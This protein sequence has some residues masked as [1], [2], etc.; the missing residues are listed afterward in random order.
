MD[1]DIGRPQCGDGIQGISKSVEIIRGQ[2]GNQVHVDGLESGVF[3]PCIGTQN[4]VGGVGPFAGV[5]HAVHHGLGVDAHAIRPMLTDGQ[6]FFCVQRVRSTALYGKFDAPG[7]VERIP[8]GIQKANHLG[9]GQCGGC[10]ASYV[11]GTH[12]TSGVFQQFAGDGNFLQKCFQ[13]GFHQIC[14]RTDGAADKTAIA[15]PGGAKR[16]THV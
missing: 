13:I 5:Q 12:M 7:Q 6:Q 14:L 8:D 15:A 4:I 10:A 9:C 1:G 11:K 2:S 3:C 16:N